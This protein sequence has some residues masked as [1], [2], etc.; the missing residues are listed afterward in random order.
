MSATAK[1]QAQMPDEIRARKG[2][3]PLVSLTVY[4]TQMAELTGAHCHF[5]P[6]GDS[7][8]MVTAFKAKF[9]KRY[10]NSGADAEAET[11]K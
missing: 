8:G 9:G 2:D 11:S 10:G 6:V 5:V 1:K 4:S 7:V 3:K